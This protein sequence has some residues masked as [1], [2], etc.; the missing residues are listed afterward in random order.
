MLDAPI[1][2]IQRLASGQWIA[3]VPVENTLVPAVV[4][5]AAVEKPVGSVTVIPRGNSVEAADKT[6]SVRS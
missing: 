5:V 6:V 1:Y 2:A 4:A 3:R